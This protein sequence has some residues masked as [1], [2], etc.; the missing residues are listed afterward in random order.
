MKNPKVTVLMPVYNAEKFLK[1]AIDSI[2]NQSFKDFEFLIINDG[3]TD[4]SKKIILSYQD[5]RIRFFENKKNLGVAKTLNRGL[6]LAKGKYVARMDAD[7]ISL[8]NRLELQ[9]RTLKG[10]KNLV[11]ISSHFDRINEKGNFISSFKL[12]HSSEEIYYEL[13]F[14]NCLG[15]PTVIFDKEIIVNEFGGHNEKYEAEDYDLWLRISKKYKIVKLNKAL[16]KVRYSRQNKTMLFMKAMG[17]SGIIISQNNLQSLIGKSIDPS[18]IKALI[19]YYPIHSSPQKIKEALA[20]LKETDI[21]I[22][23]NSPS[24]LDKSIIKKNSDNKKNRLKF[25]LIVATLFY[26]KL[27]P[28]FKTL[29]KIYSFTRTPQ[30]R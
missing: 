24:F 2:L 21:K 1:E 18:V 12:A 5:P 3:S 14:R 26:S 6:R 17:E 29:F 23:D 16:V 19:P 30:L 7:D 10:D 22:L 4:R 27:G 25:A 28:I 8:P 11:I 15:H 13:Q 20:V 9:F